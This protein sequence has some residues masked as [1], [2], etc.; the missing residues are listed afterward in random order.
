MKAEKKKSVKKEK[1]KD[2]DDQEEKKPQK[3][4]HDLDKDFDS[5]KVNKISETSDDLENQN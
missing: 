3:Q 4:M 1:Q 5:K 2:E